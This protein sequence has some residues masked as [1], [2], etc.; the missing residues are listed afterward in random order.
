MLI[1]S[2]ISGREEGLLEKTMSISSPSLPYLSQSSVE[3]GRLRTFGFEGCCA[4]VTAHLDLEWTNDKK[5]ERRKE[6]ND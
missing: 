2:F 5:E 4:K 6:K 1:C 3:S